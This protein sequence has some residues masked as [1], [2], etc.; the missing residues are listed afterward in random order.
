MILVRNTGN[1]PTSTDQY[2]RRNI[3]NVALLS[4]GYDAKL[5]EKFNLDT[6][7]GFAWAPASFGAPTDKKIGRPNSSDFM[8]TEI[9]MTAGYQLYKNLKVMALAGYMIN[10]GYYKNAA[11]NNTDSPENP[12][13]MRLQARYSF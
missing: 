6:N 10:G 8:G 11:A 2:V 3:T 12:Y 1:S 5:T 7:V 9:N 4:L 13:T